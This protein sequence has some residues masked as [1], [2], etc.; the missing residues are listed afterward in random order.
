MHWALCTALAVA[1]MRPTSGSLTVIAGSHMLGTRA[2]RN[3]YPPEAA[4]QEY[5][6]VEP[7]CD[8]VQIPL[9]G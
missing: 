6:P 3:P 2:L 8:R 5:R 4:L 1:P 9:A 7:V